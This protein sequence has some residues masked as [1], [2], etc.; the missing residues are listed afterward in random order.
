MQIGLFWA[1]DG[2][3]ATSAYLP[4]G[5]GYPPPLPVDV[6]ESAADLRVRLGDL[7]GAVVVRSSGRR[8][9]QRDKSWQRWSRA[10]PGWHNPAGP[11]GMLALAQSRGRARARGLAWPGSCHAVTATPPAG[12][13]DTVA[14][15]GRQL[16]CLAGCWRL[17]AGE[18]GRQECR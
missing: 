7:P 17:L 16:W 10:V 8:G 5:A 3:A 14:A 2:F 6:R 15:L 1:R 18:G 9:R 13:R 4:V 12:S 11:V